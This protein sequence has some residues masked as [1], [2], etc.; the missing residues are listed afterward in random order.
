MKQLTDVHWG[1][2][3]VYAQLTETYDCQTFT[4]MVIILQ[5]I[6]M[7]VETMLYTAM[8]L[9]QGKLN[10]VRLMFPTKYSCCHNS[11]RLFDYLT[12]RKTTNVHSKII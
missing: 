10:V 8:K 7:E 4:S 6:S 2:K 9:C 3:Y 12:A 1:S 5:H 11:L